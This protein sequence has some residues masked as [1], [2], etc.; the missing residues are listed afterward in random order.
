MEFVPGVR[1]TPVAQFVQ[2][3]LTGS[4]S[5][6]MMPSCENWTSATPALSLALP[7][8]ENNSLL[9]FWFGL[10]VTMVMAGGVTS[11]KFAISTK[12]GDIEK[13]STR[14]VVRMNP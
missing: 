14:L 2:L 10:G 3:S 13:F 8:I 1:I 6:Q 12:L 5:H 11:T 7:A 4:A 9:V